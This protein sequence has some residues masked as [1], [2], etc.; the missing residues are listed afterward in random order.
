MTEVI[1]FEPTAKQGLA[2]KYLWD[3]STREIGYGGA[4]GRVS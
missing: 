2:L 3:S 4:A 1:E